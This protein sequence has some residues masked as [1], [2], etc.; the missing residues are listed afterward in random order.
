MTP[1]NRARFN[2]LV[3]T[4]SSVKVRDFPS[5]PVDLEGWKKPVAPVSNYGKS[6][7]EEAFAEAFLH[8]VY[9]RDMDQDQIESFRT[10]LADAL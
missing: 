8:Y 6:S 7:I 2:D 10:V 9:D 3:R 4:N 1:A 5:G